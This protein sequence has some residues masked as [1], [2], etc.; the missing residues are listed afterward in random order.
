MAFVEVEDLGL[1]PQRFE[2][3]HPRHAEHDLLPD[4]L[5]DPPAVEAVGDRL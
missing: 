3:P 2:R 4:A 1:Q 5:L